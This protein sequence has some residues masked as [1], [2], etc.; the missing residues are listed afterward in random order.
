MNNQINAPITAV[1][2]L[3]INIDGEGI[4]TLV[5][6]HGCPLTCK[7]CLNPDTRNSTK[8]FKNYSVDSLFEEVKAHDLYFR[9]S[10]GGLTYSGGEPLLYAEFISDFIEKCPTEWT[11]FVETSLAAPFKNIELLANKIDKFYV[12]IKSLDFDIYKAY[13]GGDLS[14][15]RDNLIN[16]LELV[17]N[18]KI[19]VRVPF[20]P[21]YTTSEQQKKTVIELKGLGFEQ[22]D[23]FDYI[24]NF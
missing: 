5:G 8:A 24:T 23:M 2:P 17:G 10:K 7:Y 4:R 16:L 19:V 12:D 13:T 15:A 22:I 11:H 18:E 1:T 20:I 9:S 6:F 21:N 14:L 3:R